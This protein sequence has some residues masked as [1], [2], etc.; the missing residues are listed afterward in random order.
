M[1]EQLRHVPIRI[2]TPNARERLLVPFALDARLFL[3]A[4]GLAVLKIGH[5]LP[6]EPD[7]GEHRRACDERERQPI[8]RRGKRRVRRQV[9]R[10]KP[11]HDGD[12]RQDVHAP[13]RERPRG[14]RHVGR[15]PD[16]TDDAHRRDRQQRRATHDHDDQLRAPPDRDPVEAAARCT[17]TQRCRN[18]EPHRN[19]H[20]HGADDDAVGAGAPRAV[21]Q[22]ERQ[23]RDV[24]DERQREARVACESH[25]GTHRARSFRH[26]A[27]KAK[28]RL[29][30]SRPHDMRQAE[31]SAR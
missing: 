8:D 30:L 18:Q 10:A 24:D 27:P 19:Q 20:Q 4:L 6:Q 17:D 16:L 31:E 5:P 14:P 22:H 11:K 1:A 3:N 25:P 13:L 15:R 21:V 7:T 29:K 12:E 28:Q 9:D 23:R 2:E 26:S